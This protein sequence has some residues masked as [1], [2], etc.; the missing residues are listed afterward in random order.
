MRN[1]QIL[2][3]REV[4]GKAEEIVVFLEILRRHPREFTPPSLEFTPTTPR[5]VRKTPGFRPSY[6]VN[7]LWNSAEKPQFEP[8]FH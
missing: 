2:N 3:L 4:R 1:S 5:F 8:I 7:Y 6:V